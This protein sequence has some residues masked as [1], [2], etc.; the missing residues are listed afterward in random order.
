MST[1][2]LFLG[3]KPQNQILRFSNFCNTNFSLQYFAFLFL[4]T[5]I[6]FGHIHP[7]WLKP[8]SI[9]WISA[10][11]QDAPQMLATRKAIRACK[12]PI[13]RGQRPAKRACDSTG[14]VAGKATP[15]EPEFRSCCFKQ[16]H[17]SENAITTLLEAFEL[18][19]K[20]HWCLHIKHGAQ[21]TQT[22]KVKSCN[23]LEMWQRKTL[24]IK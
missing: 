11:Y 10:V 1:T 4:T 3:F 8:N 19:F 18:C 12:D 17:E 5:N 15:G 24:S 22:T 21:Q 6:C 9:S 14:C 23:K 20:L 16:N 7:W 2:K 13:Q